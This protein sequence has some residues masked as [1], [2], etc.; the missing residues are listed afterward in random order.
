MTLRQALNLIRG[1]SGS[2]VHL[3]IIRKT[4]KK[5][6]EFTVTRQIIK[7]PTVKSELYDGNYGYIRVSFFQNETEHDL[8]TAIT[9]LQQDTKGNLK[10][11]IF[12]LRNNP[13]GLLDSAV[14]VANTFLDSQNL[15]FNKLIVYT[16]GR[17]ASSDIQ[18]KASG[19]DMLK[20]VPM[21]VI[22]NS[23]SASA[24][25]IVAGAL[26]D[27]KR[28]TVVGEKTFGKASVQTVLPIDNDSAIKLTTALYYT[29]S[30]RSIQAK[31][32]EP[33]IT[34]PDLKVPANTDDSGNTL[35]ITEV[36]LTKHLVDGSSKSSAAVNEQQRR[37]NQEKVQKLL[38][39][40]FQ[41][42]EALNILEGI[43][44]TKGK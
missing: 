8:K 7:V 3:T 15:K 2:Q 24:A 43:V 23:G 11:V 14:D 4:E 17:I 38:Y 31:G 12:D 22:V 9:K 41:L 34:V 33:N 42:Y 29:P 32:I 39:S 36:D 30:G 18:A 40:D 6:L 13:G 44:A 20:G 25:E 35:S 16:K 27:Q 19:S 21:V 10:G 5:P 1:P 26:Q 37:I 28:A